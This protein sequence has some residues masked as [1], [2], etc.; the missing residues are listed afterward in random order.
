M[1]TYH[2]GYKLLDP[3]ML[4]NLASDPHEQ[5]NIASSHPE[6]VGEAM[7]M[8]TEW[9]AEMMRTSRTNVDPMMTVLREGGPFHCRGELERYCQRLRATGREHHADRLSKLHG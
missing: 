8:L 3:L 9:E 5:E 4:F 7:T 6:I 2:D 1:R